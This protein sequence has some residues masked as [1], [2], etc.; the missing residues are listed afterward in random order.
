M[1][2]YIADSVN[3]SLIIGK[4]DIL[5]FLTSVIASTLLEKSAKI[6]SLR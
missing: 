4:D 6:E 2:K 5:N 1:F 3:S